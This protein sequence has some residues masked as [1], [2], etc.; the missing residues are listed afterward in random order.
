MVAG[1][2]EI[3]SSIVAS[4][5]DTHA[6]YG[7]VV[8]ELASREHLRAIVPVVREALSTANVELRDLSAI[9]VTQGPGLVGSLL[10]GLTYAKAL[11]FATGSPLIAVNHVE[12]HIH[13]VLIEHPGILMPAVALVVSGGHTHLF[14]VESAGCYRLLGKT[15]D[16]AAGEAYDKVAKLLGFGYPGGP[17]IDQLAPHGNPRAIQFTA[18]R[19]KGNDLDF[20]FSGLKTAVLRWTEHN[21]V[22]AEVAARR[23]LRNVTTEEWLAV[24]P[25]RTLDVLASFQRTVIRELLRRA[26]I[27]AE[28]IGTRTILVSGGVASNRGLRESAARESRYRFYFPGAKLS[29]DNA[30][31]IAAAAYPK[32]ERQEFAG[33]NVRASAALVLA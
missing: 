31:M 12:G 4:Q 7:G 18:A 24:T 26:T 6:R 13:S 8:P 23:R 29:T 28:N 22:A 5:L 32:W 25:Q 16:D 9:A 3:R 21:D 11:C 1:G 2:R 15:R 17:I 19:M 33:L 20:S 27:S 10:V 14:A 30:A